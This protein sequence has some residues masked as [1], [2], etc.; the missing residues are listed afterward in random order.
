MLGLMMINFRLLLC[1][2]V[3]RDDCECIS[4]SFMG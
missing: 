4:V 3:Y 2:F 1:D